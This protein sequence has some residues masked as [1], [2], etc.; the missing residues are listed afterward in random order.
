M[1]VGIILEFAMFGLPALILFAFFGI[2]TYFAVRMREGSGPRDPQL[3]L[4]TVHYFFLTAGLFLML[5]GMTLLCI[6]LTMIDT[7]PSDPGV[8]PAVPFLEAVTVRVGAA[9][10]ILGGV[11]ALTHRLLLLATNDGRMRQVRRA[12]VG[13]RLAV[14]GLVV[15][16]CAAVTLSLLLQVRVD[17]AEIKPLLAVLIVWTPFWLI[18]VAILIFTTPREEPNMR[19]EA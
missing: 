3:G 2:F 8:D 17:V 9:F 6:E 13:L 10:I 4:K 16:L 11:F 15:F 19:M 18:H 5:I 14:S 7:T 12:Y 1:F